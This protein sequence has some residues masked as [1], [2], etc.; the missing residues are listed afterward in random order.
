[1]PQPSVPDHHQVRGSWILEAAQDQQVA[2]LD[3][4]GG[5]LLEPE[6]A[7][8][9]SSSCSHSPAAIRPSVHP[10]VFGCPV[11]IVHDLGSKMDAV[12][13]PMTVG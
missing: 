5:A 3:L 2:C 6:T 1:M 12:N 11:Q 7:Q 13:Y 4:V 10:G 9:P 8:K